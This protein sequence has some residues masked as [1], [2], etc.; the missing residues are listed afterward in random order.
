MQGCGIVLAQIN[1]PEPFLKTVII[2]VAFGSIVVFVKAPLRFGARNDE[3]IIW[4]NLLILVCLALGVPLRILFPVF[5]VDPVAWLAGTSLPSKRWCGKKTVIGTFAAAVAAYFC[6]FY[7]ENWKHRLL[8]TL[9][10]A[11]FEGIMGKHDNIG[12][13]VVVLLYYGL[14]Q[15]FVFPLTL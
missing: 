9:T 3:G 15:K 5:I 7:V 12:V 8:L 2:G 10:I 11:L 1:L 13:G 4:Y 6:L 14:A